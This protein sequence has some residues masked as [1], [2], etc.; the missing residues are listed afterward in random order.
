MT[1]A[2]AVAA[3]KALGISVSVPAGLLEGRSLSQLLAVILIDEVG[4][5]A[6]AGSTFDEA[7]RV[8]LGITS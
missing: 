3:L 2:E 6:C 7:L 4:V 8:A 5:N 1:Y